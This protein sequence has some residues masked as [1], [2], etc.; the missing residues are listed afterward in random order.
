VPA[1]PGTS[2]PGTSLPGTG[3]FSTGSFSTGPFSTGPFS[4][5]PAGCPDAAAA[6]GGR[7][8]AD[9]WQQPKQIAVAEHPR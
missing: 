3:S 4:T 7:R 1:P 5:G 8:L 9:G 2:R 6:G